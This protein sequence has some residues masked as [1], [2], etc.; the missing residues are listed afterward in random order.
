VATIS[1][2]TGTLWSPFQL[3][4]PLGVA[5]HH[6]VPDGVGGVLDVT[7][8]TA[9]HWLGPATRALIVGLT[10]PGTALA[11]ARGRRSRADALLLLALLL[12][13]RCALD[14][15]NSFYYALPAALALV[16]W[17]VERGERLPLAAAA[18]SA[19]VWL[20]FSRLALVD[21]RALMFAGY[22]AWAVPFAVVL[23]A[24]LYRR[25][26]AA[27]PAPVRL[28]ALSPARP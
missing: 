18:F 16:A 12:H 21:D 15:W 24:W 2:S 6:A 3:W 7:T 8:W 5:H 11:F 28:G 22:V 9:P 23:G 17:S 19:L 10:V 27:A 4:W 25:P 1:A 13:L 20:T 26:R 14:P